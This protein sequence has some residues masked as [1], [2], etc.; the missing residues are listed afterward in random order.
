MST[1]PLGRPMSLCSR[2]PTAV[3]DMSSKCQMY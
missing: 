1:H 2:V 3:E